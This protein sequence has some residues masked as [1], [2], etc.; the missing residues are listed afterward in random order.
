[1][2][3]IGIGIIC[4]GEMRVETTI[5]IFNTTALDRALTEQGLR[6]SRLLGCLI[7]K[8]WG[9]YL[10]MGRNAI[11]RDFLDLFEDD[12]LLFIDSDIVFT[13]PD[14]ARIHAELD[15]HPEFNVLAGVYYSPISIGEKPLPVVY[16]WESAAKSGQMVLSADRNLA[17]DGNIYEKDA[18]GTGFMAIRRSYL[19]E[20][21]ED[22]GDDHPLKFFR[23]AVI[24]G[25]YHGEDLEFC[26]RL[27]V[28]TGHGPYVH[29]GIQVTHI[30]S[31]MMYQ[32]DTHHM[33]GAIPL[34]FV[35]GFGEPL[36]ATFQVPE[37]PSIPLV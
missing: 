31:A 34:G 32:G 4:G 23:N 17:T 35:Q 8:P 9:P 10:D 5:S 21:D 14:I 29:T 37:P 19:K 30:K 20:L 24:N 15:A 12:Y 2:T 28:R 33:S 1:M 11:V 27:K 16:T 6:S 25:A 3:T 13:F 26:H 36:Q 22:P 7:V 18:V